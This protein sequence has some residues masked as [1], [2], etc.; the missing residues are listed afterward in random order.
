MFFVSL[1]VIGFLAMRAL[2]GRPYGAAHD[3]PNYSQPTTLDRIYVIRKK[4]VI[5][6]LPDIGKIILKVIQDPIKIIISKRI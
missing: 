1:T 6:L 3:L 4:K 2:F 5:N